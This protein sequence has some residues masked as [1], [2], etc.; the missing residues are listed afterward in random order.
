MNS[1]L[2]LLVNGKR[3][4]SAAAAAAADCGVGWGGGIGGRQVGCG[5]GEEGE[6]E[7]AMHTANHYV[8]HSHTNTLHLPSSA[9][10]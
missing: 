1:S 6:E 4:K 9:S 8:V 2:D 5:E 3:T 7:G 10:Q